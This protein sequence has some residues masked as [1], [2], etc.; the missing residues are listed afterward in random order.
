MRYTFDILGMT[1]RGFGAVLVALGLGSLIGKTLSLVLNA[2]IAGLVLAVVA[3]VLP[4]KEEERDG[5]G[6]G[7]GDN[8][9]DNGG[10]GSSSFIDPNGDGDGRLLW[11]IARP[12]SPVLRGR[13][14]PRPTT[15]AP[16]SSRDSDQTDVLSI[17]FGAVLGGPGEQRATKRTGA[18]G[19]A[20][21]L[22]R[23]G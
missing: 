10:D 3:K 2:I 23:S 8:G 11:D 17:G 5:E 13:G 18:T 7:E 19:R 15:K 12:P 1:F 16:P 22:T 20:G 6:D 21:S 4:E 14:T 9:G